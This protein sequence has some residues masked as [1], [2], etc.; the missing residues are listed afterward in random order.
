MKNTRLKYVILAIVVI[1]IAVVIYQYWRTG[2]TYDKDMNAYY[3]DTKEIRYIVYDERYDYMHDIEKSLKKNYIKVIN[4]LG[5]ENCPQ[6]TVTVYASI[7]DFHNAAHIKEKSNQIIGKSTSSTAFMMVSPIA[8]N[9]L[10]SYE[11]MTQQVPV[12]EFTH[13]VIKNMKTYKS[14]PSW[15]TESISLYEANQLRVPNELPTSMND[16]YNYT[17]NIYSIGYLLVDYI[18]DIY[19]TDKLIA[20]VHS[21]GN[22]ENILGMEDEEILVEWSNFIKDKYVDD[23]KNN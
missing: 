15:L 17:Y 8:E 16:I 2:Y 3:K 19:G 9:L 4:Q 10:H 12:H 22:M 21:G 1:S 23:N 14:I 13:C 20:L 5:V 7:K 11:E 6:I 18:I